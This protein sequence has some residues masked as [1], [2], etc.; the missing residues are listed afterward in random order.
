MP[1]RPITIDAKSIP[2]KRIHQDALRVVSRLRRQGHEAY[3]VGG[4]VRDLLLGRRPK[5]FDI[6]TAAH[7]R[8]IRRIFRNARIIGRRFKLAHIFYGDHILETATFRSAPQSDDDEDDL[9]ITDDNDFGTA[10]SDAL[11]RD[12]TINGLFLD[13]I[14]MEIHDWVGGLDD[15]DEGVLRTI[16][17][18]YVRMAE[19]PVRILRAVKFA[20]RLG[21]RI[22]DDTWEAMLA[23]AP[24]LERA[25]PPRILEEIMRLSASGTALGSF[26]MMRAC[27]ALAVL[28]PELDAFVCERDV[29]DKDVRDRADRYWRLLGALDADV[30]A[31]NEP[32][33]AVCLAVLWL[34][35]IEHHAGLVDNMLHQ[36]PD[37]DLFDVV[38]E[39]LE[40]LVQDS[41]LPRR[42]FVIARRIIAEQFRFDDVPGDDARAKLFTLT[43]HFPDALHLF[44]LRCRAWGQGWQRYEAWEQTYQEMEKASDEEVQ[45]LR[46]KGRRRKRRRPRKRRRS[47]T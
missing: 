20:T 21:F 38:T 1:K 37:V 15:V 30:Q 27:G 14:D 8:Q 43:E 10:Q 29:S 11:R 26:R 42:T 32:S 45:G 24:E 25:A 46:K 18:P 5:D 16:G 22:E 36:E 47:K 19:D 9:L 41:R 6:A 12:F 44:K 33:R 40:P 4:C 34:R 17:D 31:G 13:P 2:K 3:L 7:P 35:L 28:L 23:H 39:H